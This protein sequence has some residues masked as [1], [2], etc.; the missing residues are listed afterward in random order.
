MDR[1]GRYSLILG[2]VL[3]IAGLVLGFGFMFAEQDE[4]AKMF[5][6]VVPLGFLILFAGL[7]T[8]VL[9]SPRGDGK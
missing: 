9:F 4:L 8:V 6:M 5:L 3:T 2:L 1:I 7:S